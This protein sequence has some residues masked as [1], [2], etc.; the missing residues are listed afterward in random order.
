M[1]RTNRNHRIA[2]RQALGSSRPWILCAAVAGIAILSCASTASAQYPEEGEQSFIQ[3]FRTDYYRNKMWPIPFRQDDARSTLSYFDLQ[4]DNG[5]K[6]HN[7]IGASMFN[8]KTGQLTDSG[9]AHVRWIV[10]RAPQ[11]R[12]VVF[13]LQGDSQRIT[14]SRVESTQL[15]ISQL[16][17]VG[18][19]PQIYLTDRDAPGSSG[20]YQTAVY[21]ALTTSVPNPR[22]PTGQTP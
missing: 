2:R 9:V 4:R 7:T 15:A 14:A 20:D 17:P 13:V 3:R 18:P 11:A 22:L 21:R 5:W 8:A 16:V 10:A 19:L 12:R 1:L 6:L